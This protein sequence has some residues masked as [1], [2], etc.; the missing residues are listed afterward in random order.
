MEE[1][2]HMSEYGSQLLV[3]GESI[4]SLRSSNDVEEV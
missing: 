4:K 3:V 1:F 2:T